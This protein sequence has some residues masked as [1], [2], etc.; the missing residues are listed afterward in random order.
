MTN[1]KK[2]IAEHETPAAG[3]CERGP[4]GDG[5]RGMLAKPPR[6]EA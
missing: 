3:R 1:L 4:L 6:S 5:A 2:A